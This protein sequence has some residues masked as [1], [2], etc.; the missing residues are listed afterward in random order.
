MRFQNGK[1]LRTH[2]LALEILLQSRSF[3]IMYLKLTFQLNLL[4]T[5][6]TLNIGSFSRLLAYQ[7]E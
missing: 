7:L 4:R 5:P 6:N 3:G 2:S 1:L